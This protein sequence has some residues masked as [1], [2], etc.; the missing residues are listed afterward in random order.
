MEK[1]FRVYV[2]FSVLG[3]CGLVIL[4]H[5]KGELQGS[6]DISI[7]NSIRGIIMGFDPQLPLG[8]TESGE[9]GDSEISPEGKGQNQATQPRKV[10]AIDCKEFAISLNPRPNPRPKP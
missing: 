6:I 2:G 7:G 5:N 4:G 3:G 10:A 8:T 1:K 9:R